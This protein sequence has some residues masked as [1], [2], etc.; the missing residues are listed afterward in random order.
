[1]KKG[2]KEQSLYF[3]CA[4]SSITTTCAADVGKHEIET[5]FFTPAQRLAISQSRQAPKGTEVQESLQRYSGVVKRAEGRNA[6]WI[7]NRLQQN[8]DSTAPTIEGTVVVLNGSRLRVGDAIDIK[9]GLKKDLLPLN[10]LQ[11]R[12]EK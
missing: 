10:S 5:L 2:I 6:I 3:I 7:N 11:I 8:S 4:L 9:S 12:P 1:M